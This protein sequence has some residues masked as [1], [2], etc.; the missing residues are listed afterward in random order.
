LAYSAVDNGAFCKFC[1][2]F[3][4]KEGEKNFQLLGS[5]VL[6]KFDNWKHA[7]ESFNKHSSLEYHKQY[8]SDACNFSNA[9]KTLKLLLLT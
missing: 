7:V 8:L 9:L 4:K 1:V 5:L 3:S 2:A 6:K